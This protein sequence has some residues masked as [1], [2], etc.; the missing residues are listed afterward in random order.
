[1]GR[2]LLGSLVC[3]AV[4]LSIVASTAAASSGLT[5]HCGGKVAATQTGV[6]LVASRIH[7]TATVY[8]PSTVQTHAARPVLGCSVARTVL[9][10]FLVAKLTRPLN[11]CTDRVLRGGGCKVGN[12]LCYENASAP[13]APRG[14]YDEIC[15]HLLLD[16]FKV[17]RRLTYVFFRETDHDHG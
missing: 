17:V 5:K 2:V 15:N 6:T 8:N 7:I 4:G 16:R 1:M 10:E 12:W 3:V 9:D 13:A 11:V 14:S